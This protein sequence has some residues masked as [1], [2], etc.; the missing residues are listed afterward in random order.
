MIAADVIKNARYMLS[1]T[2][3]QRWTDERLL[4]LLNDGLTDIAKNTILFIDTMF[5]EL[6]NDQADYDLSDFAF[7]I[8]RVEYEDKPLPL[9][10]FSEMDRKQ[11]LWQQTTGPKLKTYLLDKQREANL[12]VYPLLQNSVVDN[13]DFGGNYGIMTGVTY[14]ELELNISGT[15]GGLGG[16][17]EDGFIKVFYI[18][19][20][21]KVT[22]LTTTL[23]VSDVAEKPL[24]HYIAG[25]ALRDNQDTQNRLIAK[26]ELSLYEKSLEEYN[27]VK[28]KNFSQ[29]QFKTTYNPTGA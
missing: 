4:S 1:D 23:F 16:V 5:V 14:S 29:S 24:A 2:S 19:K 7:K 26:E 10:F 11:P 17:E 13:I 3:P 15:L 22:D 18:R 6:I 27:I 20:H 9:S 8:I 21:V 12:K 28:A 25:Y